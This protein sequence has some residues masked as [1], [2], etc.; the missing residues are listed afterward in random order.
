MGG[1]TT[2]GLN[3]IMN[4]IE[5]LGFYWAPFEAD[6]AIITF[7]GAGSADETV[8]IGDRT[9]TLKASPSSANEVDIGA[10]AS[11]TAAN[12]GA[13]INAGSGA[14]TDYGTGTAAHADVLAIVSG[15][16]VK[17]IMHDPTASG[18]SVSETSAVASWD[19]ATMAG[20]G[21]LSSSTDE[22]RLAVTG[23]LGAASSGVVAND[24]AVA[25]T[26]SASITITH[27]VTY[28]AASSGN[29]IN[30]SAAS[31]V[32]TLADNDEASFDAGQLT[33]TATSA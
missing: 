24:A 14:G 5:G 21:E 30:W 27:V 2:A 10:D 32:Q 18:L 13:A 8:V 20:A 26:A 6:S 28:D 11:G 22:G 1:F 7:G 17:V 25:W 9:Y 31:P 3:A 15:A 19:V 23:T 16:T 4:E 12:L 33:L 29:V